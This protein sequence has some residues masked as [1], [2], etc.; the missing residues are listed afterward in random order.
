[1]YDVAIAGAGPVGLFLACE[2]GL[3]GRSVLVLER[4]PQPRSPWKSDPLGLRG[5]SAASAGAF[6]R[7]GLLDALLSADHTAPSRGAGHFAGMMLDPAAV[8]VTALPFRLPGPALDG[9]L[10]NLEAV[11]SVLAARATGLGVHI[12]RGAEVEA[13]E[14]HEDRVVLRAGGHGYEARWLVGCDGGRSTVRGL[15]GFEFAGTGPQFTGYVMLATLADPESLRPG[16]NLTPAGMYLRTPAEGYVGLLDFDG[17]AFD[18]SQRPTLEHLQAVLRRVSGTSVTLRD[19]RLVSTFTDRA[20]QATAY[21][22]GRVLLAG[23]AAHIHS[24]LGAQG[25]NLGLGDALNLGWK[26]AATV[27]GDAPDGLLDTYTRERHPVGAWALDWTRAQ[28]AVMRPDPAAQAIQ[29]VVRDLLGTRDGTTYVFQKVSGSSIRYDLGDAEPL[30]GRDAPDF[31]LGDGTRLGDLLR[32]GRGVLLDFTR[33]GR[34]HDPATPWEHRIRYVHG[35]AEHDLGYGAALVRPD[36]VVAWADGHAPDRAAFER[37]A[38]DWFGRPRRDPGRSTWISSWGTAQELAQAAEPGGG[39]QLP[40]DE[41]ETTSR[42]TR[43]GAQTVR[44]VARATAGGTAARVALSNAFNRPPVR[45]GAARLDGHPLTF[46]GRDTVVVPTGA[47]IHSDPVELEVPAGADLTVSLYLPDDDVTPT[48]HAVGLRTAWLAPGDQTAAPALRDATEFRSYLWLAGLDVLAAPA[49]ATVVAFG[50]SL[51]DGLETTPDADAAW[52]SVLARRLAA[53]ADLPPRAVINMGI[54][55]NRVLRETDGLGAGALARFDRDVLGRPGV[56]WVVL[57]EGL[58]DLFFGFVPGAPD[59][60]R[61]TAGDIIAGYRQLI[62]RA[63]P[64]GVRVVGCTLPPIGG[65]PFHTE[66]LER[67]RQDVNRWIRGGGE[68]DAVVDLDAA[69]RDPAAP[70]RVRAGLLSADGVHPNDA[71]HEVIAAA[72]DPELFR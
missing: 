43:L 20:M 64:H 2:L 30:T 38:G 44:M 23:D 22:R 1:M 58:N 14:P 61:A 67:M 8:D 9:V 18:R 55:G 42:P 5:L 53:R 57:S 65:A 39:P 24:P 60:E 59:H 54:A 15:A 17:G 32:D 36:G 29:G 51:V 33:D 13:V 49:A 21:R 28:A 11:E 52:P 19:V 50:D 69:T 25:L 7:R 68:F 47:L 41:A 40:D 12:R 63:R 70:E 56:R 27:R 6:D 16:F 35:P 62:G 66:E 10:T 34:L 26:L 45:I 46:G 71:G 48:T 37:A 3:A 4:D 72:F 31:R